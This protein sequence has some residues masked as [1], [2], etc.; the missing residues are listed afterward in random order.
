MSKKLLIA[1]DDNFLVKMY[2]MNIE[3]DDLDVEI[4]NDGS[5]AIASIEKSKPDILLLDL[6][7]P[8]VDGFAVLEHCKEKK[9]K[10]PIIVMS[11]LSQEVDMQKCKDLGATD[12]FVKS[13]M[14]L[15][16]LASKVQKYL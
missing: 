5:S 10:F 11:N 2:K 12:Y 6:L 8:K 16:E 9:Y 4:V 7:M 1:E 15:E 14:D 13:D 3:K